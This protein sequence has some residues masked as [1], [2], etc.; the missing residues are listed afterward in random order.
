MKRVL[1]IED[2]HD[3]AC[4]LAY[5]TNGAE[6]Q[7]AKTLAEAIACLSC[8]EADRKPFDVILCDM[9][10][11]D[12]KP[13]QV[14]AEVAMRARGAALVCLTGAADSLPTCDAAEWKINI[15]SHDDILRLIRRA[16]R[17]QQ[18]T[19]GYERSVR[20]LETYAA[21]RAILA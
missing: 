7:F 13:A 9:K 2:D 12:A 15:N 8:A 11:P 19:P 4:F 20:A 14:V 3:F 21:H 17:N 16:Q 18:R 6:R 1:I 10:L 5:A